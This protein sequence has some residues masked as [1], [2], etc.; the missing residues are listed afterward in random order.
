[1]SVAGLVWTSKGDLQTVDR[2][3]STGA[4]PNSQSIF[5]LLAGWGSAI[6]TWKLGRQSGRLSLGEGEREGAKFKKDFSFKG[7]RGKK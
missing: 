7:K 2:S 1:M 3:T 6:G 5:P 4:V